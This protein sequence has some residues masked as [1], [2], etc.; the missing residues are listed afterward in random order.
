M[1]VPEQVEEKVKDQDAEDGKC[2][3]ATS[4]LTFFFFL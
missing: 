3:N 1:G 2:I 4:R